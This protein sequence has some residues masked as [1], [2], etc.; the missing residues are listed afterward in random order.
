MSNFETVQETIPFDDVEAE[1]PYDVPVVPPTRRATARELLFAEGSPFAPVAREEIVGIDEVLARVD[2]IVSW[3]AHARRLEEL[4]APPEPG[5]LFHGPPGTGKTLVARYLATRANARF[6]DVRD[7]PRSRPRLSPADVAEMFAY[8]RSA[9]E[10]NGV[11]VVLFWDEFELAAGPRSTSIPGARELVLA[12]RAELDGVRGR[13]RGVLLIACSNVPAIDPALMRPGRIGLRLQFT[14]PDRHGRELL[15]RRRLSTLPT[16]EPIEPHDLAPLLGPEAT[17]ATIDE[18]VASAWRRAVLRA[19]RDGRRPALRQDDLT[20][21]LLERLLGPRPPHTRL[22]D[23]TRFRIAVHEAGHAL[24]AAAFGIPLRLVTIRPGARFL[25]RTIADTCN[26]HAQTIAELKAE[27]RI[28]LAG[29]LAEQVAGLEVQTGGEADTGSATSV[30]LRLVDLNA[31]GRRSGPFNPNPA[32][33]RSSS[34]DLSETMLRRLDRDAHRLLRAARR[35]T[36]RTLRRIGP[37]RIKT[38][39]RILCERETLLGAELEQEIRTLLGGDPRRYARRP[40]R[41][42]R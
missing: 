38:L 15:L 2:D 39:A 33:L 21:A 11:P 13:P 22:D 14:P 41:P 34:P 27:M 24:A 36:L 31:I 12:L 32:R 1:E 7:F 18:A 40:W 37:T 5:I 3:L 30:A 19:V 29:T 4:G 35:E 9:Y 42:R 23:D 8:A 25:G 20:E 26:E 16:E 17:A 28:A 6:V 10:R